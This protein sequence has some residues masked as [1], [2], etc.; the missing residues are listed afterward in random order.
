MASL[1][2]HGSGPTCATNGRGRRPR[3]DGTTLPAKTM[4]FLSNGQ[5]RTPWTAFYA[6]CL[7]STPRAAS[8]MSREFTIFENGN[9]LL[10]I[11]NLD[12]LKP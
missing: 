5:V 4:I 2:P 7:L 6:P 3:E 12:L 8:V 10:S 11:P 9:T 1:R